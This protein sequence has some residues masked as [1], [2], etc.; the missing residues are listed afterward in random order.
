MATNSLLPRNHE[1]FNQ[2]EY[3]DEFFIK[4]KK[5]AFEWYGGYN[6]IKSYFYNNKIPKNVKI[7]II[8]CGNS[9][10]SND[11]YDDGYTNITNIDF[12]QLV[13]DEMKQKN[14]NIRTNMKWLVMDMTSMIEFSNNSFD[15]ILD[16]G[17]LD[18]L[19]SVDSIDIQIK[20]MKMFNEISRIL[21]SCG[22][23][24]CISLCESYILKAVLSYFQHDTEACTD[25]NNNSWRIDVNAYVES[26]KIIHTKLIPY[27]LNIRR[28]I[29]SN[30]TLGDTIAAAD[31]PGIYMNIDMFYNQL[32][33]PLLI[34]NKVLKDSKPISSEKDISN[35][36][37]DIDGIDLNDASDV[38]SSCDVLLKKIDEMQKYHFQ[39]LSMG[40]IKIGRYEVIDFHVS[41]EMKTK[42]FQEKI[43][44]FSIYVLDY[45]VHA[46]RDCAVFII[47][48][49]RES[50]FQFSTQEGLSE[51]AQSAQ[52]KRLLAVRRNKPHVFN[53]NMQ[54]LQNEL[55][56]LITSLIPKVVRDG[57]NCLGPE[58]LEP[59]PYS[60]SVVGLL[61]HY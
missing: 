15:I 23:Y 26:E 18:A 48:A 50:E 61:L 24:L 35:L 33:K 6:D 16:K 44:R 43:P 38:I 49:G 1:Q 46:V 40:Q 28:C 42:T 27:L 4:T 36:D 13:I 41:D 53:K 31:K 60:K 32:N 30:A 17:A 55:N 52:C 7:L 9:N 47:P 29:S 57:H 56:P 20:A 59:V 5:E 39:I 2:K 22:S 45:T 3:W 8:G 21:T 11:M 14:L 25:A 58:E 12:S 37:I 51:I 19:M 54:I 34:E 10:L